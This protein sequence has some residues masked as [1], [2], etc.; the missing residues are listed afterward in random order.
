MSL[1]FLDDSNFKSS[2]VFN[3]L[4]L[5]SFNLTISFNKSEFFFVFVS[6]SLI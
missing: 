3:N 6:V 2:F 5:S 4:L 1:S